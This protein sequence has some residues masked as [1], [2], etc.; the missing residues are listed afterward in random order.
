MLKGIFKNPGKL[1]PSLKSLL[2]LLSLFLPPTIYLH[3]SLYDK[4]V[5]KTKFPG[6][7]WIAYNKLMR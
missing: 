5:S 4:T 2:L 1:I 6:H 3:L 7:I